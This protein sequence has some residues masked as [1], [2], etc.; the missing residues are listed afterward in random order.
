MKIAGTHAVPLQ[1]LQQPDKREEGLSLKKEIKELFK[2]LVAGEK[3]GENEVPV[4]SGNNLSFLKELVKTTE[5]EVPLLLP[6]TAGLQQEGW[7]SLASLRVPGEEKSDQELLSLLL[8]ASAQMNG[9]PAGTG[10]KTEKQGAE[11][12]QPVDQGALLFPTMTGADRS[13]SVQGIDSSASP[14]PVEL[15]TNIWKEAKHLLEGYEAEKTGKV[16]SSILKLLDQWTS[17]EKQAG[18]IFHL[19]QLTGLPAKPANREQE[20]W[21]LLLTAQRGRER[22]AGQHRYISSAAVTSKDISSWLKQA[23]A[24]H[25]GEEKS[26]SQGVTVT[27]Q[28]AGSMPVSQ[29]EQWSS[30]IPKPEGNTGL[31]RT[32]WLNE[33]QNAVRKSEFLT[34]PGG[35]IQMLL[36]LKPVH[37]GEV[38]VRL[39]EIDGVMTARLLVQ[40]AGAKEML[41]GNLHQLRHL[42]APHQVTV[43]KQ[44]V[45]AANL[46]ETYQPD[47]QD[48]KHKQQQQ[49]REQGKNPENGFYPEEDAVLNFSEL[50][51]EEKE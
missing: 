26:V 39:T 19:E 7:I 42:F 37:L 38:T 36:K 30:Q 51:N 5:E 13:V 25:A 24:R 16:P 28:T 45:Q 9:K 21:S 34:K 3:T 50:L 44:E 15:L 43:E 18:K 35:E 32:Q 17:L 1:I 11:S 23:F 14:V 2:S 10:E 46:Q 4:L 47:E 48:Q 12:N 33:F 22:L 8:G 29:L 49:N 27:A 6:E 31:A 20:I 40:T 41:E